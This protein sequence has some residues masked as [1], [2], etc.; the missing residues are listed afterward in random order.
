VLLDK[1]SLYAHA[2]TVAKT[3]AAQSPVAVVGT[4]VFM[5]YSRDHTTADALEHA[6]S[7][8]SFSRVKPSYCA[9]Q[10]QATWN[11]AMLQTED[12]PKA[13]QAGTSKTPGTFSK[14]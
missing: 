2:L 5:N 7:P 8:V 3:I 13:V 10:C 14:L 4:K 11:M 12:I 1:P 6:V 9:M